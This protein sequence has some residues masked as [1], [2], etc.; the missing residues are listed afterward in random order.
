MFVGVAVVLSA[1]VV[2]YGLSAEDREFATD[3]IAQSH[4]EVSAEE[5]RDEGGETDNKVAS[6]SV[7]KHEQREEDLQQKERKRSLTTEEH[8]REYFS[9]IPI[10][11]EIARCESTF[12]HT[13]SDGNVLRG[14][15][16]NS[17]LGV[18]QINKRYHAA[19]ARELGIDI[20]TREGNMEYARYLY[21]KQGVQPWNAS[22]PCWGSTYN[23]LASR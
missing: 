23:E 16:D 8:V 5:D 11:V 1:P 17:D 3:S 9:D 2:H 7:T 12:R 22:R 4:E 14:L 20:Y 19:R 21:E 6:H 13:D 15:V 10:L 18:M